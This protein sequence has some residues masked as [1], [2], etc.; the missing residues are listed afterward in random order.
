MKKLLYKEI[1]LKSGDYNYWTAERI[2]GA[3]NFGNGKLKDFKR[4]AANNKA[5][6]AA[7]GTRY[8]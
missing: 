6:T 7:I 2:K 1:D 5:I 4:Y 3:F 8:M